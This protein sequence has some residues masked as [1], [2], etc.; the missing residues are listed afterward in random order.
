MSSKSIFKALIFIIGL[1]SLGCDPET[2]KSCDLSNLNTKTYVGTIRLCNGSPGQQLDFD[3]KAQIMVDDTVLTF[4][5]YSSDPNFSFNHDIVVL[6][7][8]GI[9]EEETVHRL[10]KIDTDSL[11]GTISQRASF[12]F[13]YMGIDQCERNSFFEGQLYWNN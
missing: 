9:I 12:L 10:F 8:C 3:G 2:E 4:M 11:V 6:D 13:L 5:V 1:V 7:K